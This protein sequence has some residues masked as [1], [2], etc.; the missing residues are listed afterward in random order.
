MARDPFVA[1]GAAWLVVGIAGV[2]VAITGRDGLAAV[3]PDLAIDADALGGA[4]TGIAAGA[5]GIGLAHLAV[6]GGRR[7]GRAS[8]A[9][10]GILLAALLAVGFVAL[11]MAAVAS[12]QREPA[13][14][15]AL[16][17][18]AAGSGV[19]GLGYGWLTWRL[20]RLRRSGSAV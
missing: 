12:A 5:L 7:T 1:G 10:A 4:L 19:I 17:A 20:V 16:A 11:A 8:A 3:I 14:A 13:L 2:V 9:A 18:G 6:A 15:P